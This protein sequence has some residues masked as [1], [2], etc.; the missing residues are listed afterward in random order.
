MTEK[1][2][3]PQCGSKLIGID[4]KTGLKYCGDCSWKQEKEIVESKICPLLSIATAKNEEWEFCHKEGC[5]FY[6]EKLPAKMEKCVFVRLALS[7][8]MIAE[9]RGTSLLE[10]S[11]KRRMASVR[12][13]HR[14]Q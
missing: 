8:G 3:C 11:L 14:P 4:D 1:E 10:K 7:V 12:S 5:A 13:Q 2:K 6:L 9:R